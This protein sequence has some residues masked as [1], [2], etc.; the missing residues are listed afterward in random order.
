MF[1]YE[2]ASVVAILLKEDYCVSSTD[3]EMIYFGLT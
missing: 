1:M 2:C 3:P